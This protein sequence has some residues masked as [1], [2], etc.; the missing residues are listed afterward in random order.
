MPGT[1]APLLE[2]LL[3]RIDPIPN[4][5]GCWIWKGYKDKRS[6]GVIGRGKV[7]EGNEFAHRAMYRLLKGEIPEGME[8]HHWC[9]NPPCVNP[10]HLEPMTP[11]D[12]KK[13]RLHLVSGNSAKTECPQGHPYD[14]VNTY[15]RPDG[16]RD[17]HTCRRERSRRYEATGRRRPR[18]SAA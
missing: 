14:E 18:R 6:Y 5:T 15:H 9:F 1:H 7:G 2:R 17:C 3:R 12:N 10:R 8:L 13:W 11:E 16:G 4:P